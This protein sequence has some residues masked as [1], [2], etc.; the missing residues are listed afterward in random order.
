LLSAAFAALTAILAKA[1]VS[2]IDPNLATAIR[3][4]V[5]VAF[6]W[7]IAIMTGFN[8]PGALPGRADRA[9]KGDRRAADGR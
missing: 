5:V 4:P 2:G 6:T 3:I 9:G 1:G 7:P 8:G